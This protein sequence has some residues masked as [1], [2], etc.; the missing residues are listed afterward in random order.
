MVIRRSPAIGRSATPRMPLVALAIVGAAMSAGLASCEKQPPA[1]PASTQARDA[2]PSGGGA[3]S[4]QPESKQAAADPA[5]LPI[6]EVQISG[7]TF[8]LERADTNDSRV[9]GLSGRT[10]IKPDG[11]MLFV[12]ADAARRNFV[13]RD[14]PIGIDIIFLD[15]TGRVV[16]THKMKP[17]EP[18]R[19]GESDETYERR[20]RLY[21][22]G[23]GAQFAIELKADT[24]DQLKLR[25]G[26]QIKLDLERLK[27]NAK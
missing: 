18:R 1:T 6:E 19:P 15:P 21:P 7:K 11:G 10:E 14:C 2:R 24:L 8:K 26:D 23:Y 25:N 5:A 16:A 4:V 12:F 22:S 17:E 27:R 13:M 3:A 20:L 9:K